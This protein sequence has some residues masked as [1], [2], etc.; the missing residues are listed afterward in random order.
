MDLGPSGTGWQALKTK[1][2]ENA[3]GTAKIRSM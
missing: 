1:S 3:G 2:A